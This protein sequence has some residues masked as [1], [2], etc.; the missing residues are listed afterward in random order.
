MS[1]I[2]VNYDLPAG[3]RD[4]KL[5]MLR[6]EALNWEAKQTLAVAF[7]R[8][9]STHQFDS[10]WNRM[11]RTVSGTVTFLSLPLIKEMAALVKL[12][13]SSSEKNASFE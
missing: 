3:S 10:C 4:A 1:K 7:T 5:L 2:I 11:M 8:N 6:A 13:L 9:C 12:T